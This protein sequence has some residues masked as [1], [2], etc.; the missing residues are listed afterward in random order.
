[1]KFYL[2]KNNCFLLFL[3]MTLSLGVVMLSCKKERSSL[4]EVVKPEEEDEEIKLPD[5]LKVVSFNIEYGMR[6]DKANDYKNFVEWVNRISPDV[7]ALQEVNGFRQRSLEKLAKRW[8]HN[9]VITNVKATDSFPV[10]I[11][12]KYPIEARR[13]ITM[14]VSHGA[15]FARLE[16]TGFNIIVAHLWPQGYWHDK[17]DGLGTEYRLHEVELMLDSTIRKFPDEEY[18]TFMGD[19]NA[20]SRKDYFPVDEKLDYRVID[21]VLSEEFDDV[22]HYKHGYKA[23]ETANYPWEYYPGRRIDF[24]FANPAAQNVLL[25]AYPIYDDFTS[26]YSDHFHAVC[27][28]F[29]LDK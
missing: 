17:A 16:N 11:T 2:F 23:N 28:I 19:F 15:I 4:Q 18:W 5:T 10:A 13:K 24:M 20:V 3:I 26:K 6:A 22:I 9:Y 12:S 1:M 21:L 25:D 14:D 29:L 27:G 7:L 8:G